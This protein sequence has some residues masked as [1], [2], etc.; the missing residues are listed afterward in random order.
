M[1]MLQLRRN[2]TS[3]E[4]RSVYPSFNN[5]FTLFRPCRFFF[6]LLFSSLL[7]PFSFFFSV[8]HITLGGIDI[9]LVFFPPFSKNEIEEICPSRA[10]FP[11]ISEFPEVFKKEG[12]GLGI[13]VCAPCVCEGEDRPRL[14]HN[15]MIDL[16][17][18]I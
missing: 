8:R 1:L 17:E 4:S 11:E 5:R 15:S 18:F 12:K 3:K 14:N 13:D 10:I 9:C 7:L 6:L 2:P 16:N